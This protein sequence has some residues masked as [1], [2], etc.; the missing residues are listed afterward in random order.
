MLRCMSWS[1][2]RRVWRFLLCKVA[3]I[4]PLSTLS[5]L[6]GSHSVQPTPKEWGVVLHLLKIECLHKLITVLLH[7]RFTSSPQFIHLFHDKYPPISVWTHVYLVYTLGCSL[8]IIYILVLKLFQLWASGT[9]SIGSRVPLTLLHFF[10]FRTSLL[11]GIIRW[12][13]LLLNIFFSN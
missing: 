11:S 5:S 6:G 7:Q 8:I 9:L 13:R 12:S 3:P 2:W 10:F 4:S 1:E